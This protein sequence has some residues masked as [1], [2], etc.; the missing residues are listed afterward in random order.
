MGERHM[1]KR[2]AEVLA[3]LVQ[4]PQIDG[5]DSVQALHLPHDELRVHVHVHVGGLV[6]LRKLQ[7]Q[8]EA[9]ILSNVICLVVT[10]VSDLG[11]QH[12]ACRRIHQQ[13]AAA[14]ATGIA[15]RRAVCVGEH[16][17]E[18]CIR[19]VAGLALYG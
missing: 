19:N 5:L 9:V 8:H 4:S 2:R 6:T 14:T 1:R 18:D 7:R 16:G 13:R 15:A 17:T 10:H 11:S 12:A 3:L